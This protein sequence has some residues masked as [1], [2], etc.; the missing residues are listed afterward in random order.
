LRCF[1]PLIDSSDK[2]RSVSADGKAKGE[3]AP[4]VA[5]AEVVGGEMKSKGFATECEGVDGKAIIA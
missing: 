2:Q 3:A 1:L 4:A 5:P